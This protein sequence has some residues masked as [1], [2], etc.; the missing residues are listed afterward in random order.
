[1]KRL[2]L[3]LFILLTGVAVCRISTVRGE[4]TMLPESVY[5]GVFTGGHCQGIALDTQHRYIYYSFTTKLVKTDL[6]GNLIGTVEGLLGHL[7]CIDFCDRDGKVYGSLEYKH[8]AIGQGILKNLGSDA[9]VEEG[10]YIAVFDVDRIDRPGMDASRDGVMK[11]VYMKEVVRDYMGTGCSEGKTC[12]HRYGCSGIDGTTFGPI[13][14]STDKKE[15]LFVAYG[16]YSEID[17]KDN[18]Y[19]VLLC[20]DTEGWDRYETVLRQDAM[21]KNGPDRP[22]RKFFVYT[23][24]TNWGVQNL[25]Y[26]AFSGNY[27]M[28]VYPGK[29]PSFPNL[30]LYIIDG[31]VPPV[32]QTLRGIEPAEEGEV[33]TLL[34]SAQGGETPGFSFSHGSTGLYSLGDGRFYV[35]HHG[36]KDGAHDTTV[37]LY[38]WDQLTDRP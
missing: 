37:R 11:T 16:V 7:G 36:K 10:F 5:S 31:S 2:L 1:M 19:Q 6:E 12:P 9:Q 33:L 14:G 32:R 24:N 22:D 25:E 35:S 23:G 26:D 29:K 20:F 13:P 17:R 15:Y 38:T 18:D 34:G 28:A 4:K 3:F 8:D 21:H 27:L 30:P